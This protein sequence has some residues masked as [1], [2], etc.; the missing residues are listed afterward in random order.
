[1]EK[2]I[3][4]SLIMTHGDCGLVSKMLKGKLGN[5]QKY[6]V[7][8]EW[9]DNAPI[10]DAV[11]QQITTPMI[12]SSDIIVA[13]LDLQHKLKHAKLHMKIATYEEWIE[14]WFGDS[15]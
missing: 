3:I 5:L 10:N 12:F 1:L 9:L 2:K 6:V 14:Y 15:S 13:L 7:V 4:L 8:D 11:L